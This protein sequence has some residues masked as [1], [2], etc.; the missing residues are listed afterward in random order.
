MVAAVDGKLK[1]INEII[2]FLGIG[3][4]ERDGFKI[5]A[6]HLFKYHYQGDILSIDVVNFKDDCS[7]YSTYVLKPM[8]RILSSEEK[9]LF[10]TVI[11][12]AATAEFIFSYKEIVC[13]I[14]TVGLPDK[15]TPIKTATAFYPSSHFM[16]SVNEQDDGSL[17]VELGE[18]YLEY[19]KGDIRRELSRK[20]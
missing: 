8:T 1:K 11:S 15:R 6:S 10:G 7:K 5:L 16:L 4:V 19:L 17:R 2:Y 9:F 18:K 14:L 20:V 13:S 12:Q 3:F